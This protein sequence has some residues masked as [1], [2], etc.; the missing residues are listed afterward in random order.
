M[1]KELQSARIA[2]RFTPTEAEMLSE[3]SEATGMSMTDVVRQAIRREYAEKVGAPTQARTT[4][5]K[6]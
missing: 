5:P 6:R 2:I 1:V 4:K 3:L